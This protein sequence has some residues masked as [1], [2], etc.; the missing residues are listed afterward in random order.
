M[1]HPFF[2]DI[3]IK[4]VENKSL[5]PPFVPSTNDFESIELN[6]DVEKQPL[7]MKNSSFSKKA[8]NDVKKMQDTFEKTFSPEIENFSKNSSNEPL[9][10]GTKKV[11]FEEEKE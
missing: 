3:D 10:G 2:S 7:Q 9:L 4:A 6:F 8:I 5:S 1:D 11:K